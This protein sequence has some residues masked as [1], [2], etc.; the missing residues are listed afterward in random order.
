M[1]QPTCINN[2]VKSQVFKTTHPGSKDDLR[3]K[4]RERQRN[5]CP[6]QG[7]SPVT[8]RYDLTAGLREP[9]FYQSAKV[10]KNSDGHNRETVPSVPRRTGHKI[11]GG[12]KRKKALDSPKKI[13]KKRPPSSSSTDEDELIERL[14][15]IRKNLKALDQDRLDF[16]FELNEKGRQG[17]RSKKSKVDQKVVVNNSLVEKKK[18]KKKASK[19]VLCQSHFKPKQEL[20]TKLPPAGYCKCKICKSYFPD[21]VDSRKLHLSQHPDRVFRVSLPSDSYYYDVEDAITYLVAHLGIQKHEIYEKNKK[22]KLIVNPTNLRGFSCDLCEVL[23]T[24]NEE[25]FMRHMKEECR[26]KEKL[27]RQKHLISFCRGCQVST[28]FFAQIFGYF[29]SK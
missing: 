16:E 22:N 18:K 12:G 15:T 28:I 13:S 3:Y 6:S 10:S 29:T 25:T 19:L 21:N 20:V 1:F 5:R 26:I 4:I 8:I 9:E 24:N 14:T 11:K 23:D 7:Y 2:N 27:E 17:R